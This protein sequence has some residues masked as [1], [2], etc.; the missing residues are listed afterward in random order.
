MTAAVL[1]S[2][3]V[4]WWLGRSITSGL[5]SLT[6]QVRSIAGGSAN[7]GHV[8]LQSNDELQL[9]ADAFNKLLDGLALRESKLMEFTIS[10][11]QQS[12]ELAMA[13]TEAEEA[14]KAKSAFFGHHE[15]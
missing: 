3:L 12:L 1:F 13:L 6:Q 10:M 8:T 9:L 2:I 5:D 11:E 15:P 7:R 4:A 14:T